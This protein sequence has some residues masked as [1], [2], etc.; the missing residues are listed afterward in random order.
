M[1]C[2][3][4]SRRISQYQYLCEV[5]AETKVTDVDVWETIQRYEQSSIQGFTEEMKS[6]FQQFCNKH[7]YTSTETGNPEDT[8]VYNYFDLRQKAAELKNEIKVNKQNVLIKMEDYISKG[9]LDLSE[10]PKGKSGRT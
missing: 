4:G 1:N 8:K 10:K 6:D 9:I 5:E 3:R 2:E 7:C